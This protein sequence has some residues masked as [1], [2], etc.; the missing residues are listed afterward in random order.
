MIDMLSSAAGTTPP[1]NRSRAVFRMA[2]NDRTAGS[3]PVWEKPRD[4][5]HDIETVLGEAGLSSQSRNTG[6]GLAY[7]DQGR[8]DV[9]QAQEFG[10]GDLIDMINPLQHIPLVSHLYRNITGDEIRPVA[11]VIGSTIYGGPVG[12]AASVANVI[13]EYETG[14][15]I[16]GNV[17]AL[18]VDGQK[19]SYRSTAVATAE[20]PEARLAAALHEGE[21]ESLPETILGFVD[22]RGAREAAASDADL[23]SSRAALRRFVDDQGNIP[24]VPREPISRVGLSPLPPSLYP[25][26]TSW[27]ANEQAL[28]RYLPAR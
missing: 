18:A 22:M 25:S 26:R 24:G 10:F 6:P 27:Q 4:F 12:A 23:E 20:A 3:M 1:D 8:E 13:V 11:R 2:E 21:R 16:A 28:S 7:A 5:S 9:S 19:P 17:V 14:R 15:D